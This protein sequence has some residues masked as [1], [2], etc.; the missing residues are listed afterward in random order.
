MEGDKLFTVSDLKPGMKL[1]RPVYARDLF[2]VGEG[3]VLNAGLI[4]RLKRFTVETVYV[5]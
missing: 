4:K 1:S 2:L 3:T 5:N